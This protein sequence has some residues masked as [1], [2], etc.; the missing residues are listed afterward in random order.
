MQDS[1]SLEQAKSFFQSGLEKLNSHNFVGAEIDFQSSLKY[2]PNRL[3]T[4]IN[5]SIV[6]INLNKFENAEKL[7]NQ[8]LIHH[9]KN[10]ELLIGLVEIYEKLINNKPDYAEAYANLGNTFRELNMHEEALDAYNTAVMLNPKL[11]GV[12]LNRGNIMLDQKKYQVALAE[13]DK[14]IAIKPD[15][16]SAYSNRGIA[17]RGLKR[18]DDAL[19][20]YEL[21]IK[22]KPD[23]AEAYYNQGIAQ[24]ELNYSNEALASYDKAIEINPDYIQAY[25]NRGNVLQDLNR[26]D[27][28]LA[29]NDR[30]IEINPDYAEA[31]WNKSLI[32]LMIGDFYKGWDLYTK[33]W[34]VKSNVS[35]KLDTKIPNWDGRTD[36]N[37]IKIL[38]WAEQGIGDEIFYFGILKNLTEINSKITY[39]ADIRL[40]TLFKRSMPEVEFIDRNNIDVECNE[41]SF[42]YQAP[43][44]DIGLMCSVNSALK[45]KKPKP[46]FIIN[47]LNK[48][49][50]IKIN[51]KFNHKA[52]CGI[53]WKSANQNIGSSKSLDLIELSPLLIIEGVEFVSL[54]YGST[55][56]EIN[57][58]EKKIGKKIHTV[59]ELDIYN[60]IDGLVS[61][62]SDCDIIVTTSN[63]TAH[64][65]GSIG[66]K[67][68][69][70]LPFSKGKIWYWHSGKG[71][72]TWYPSL[73]LTSQTEMN[74]WAEP[75]TKSKE[76]IL[77]Q[78]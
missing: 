47:K 24:S 29:S 77:E 55:K 28:A 50:S 76:W 15:F 72:S 61:L 73:L 46:F 13:Y 71:Q 57:F 16:A 64:L 48:T 63:I 49:G 4:I 35:K 56:D 18:L 2:V 39:S 14:A 41:N 69:V 62:I 43:I 25:S 31:Y 23:Y 33:R 67:G 12:F 19:T 51:K 54:Q 10:K 37:K 9:P 32:Y 7:I 74:N 52:L 38:F 44:G 27:E 42:D 17:L 59:E 34:N 1:Q 70:L 53:S 68:I 66:K 22:I 8:G 26:L 3:S 45:H 5:L 78:L 21:A 11:E 65:T 36:N 40:H 6:L 20:S 60:D 30:A 75:I 58:V